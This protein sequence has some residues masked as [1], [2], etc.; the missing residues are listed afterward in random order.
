M[1]AATPPSLLLTPQQARHLLPVKYLP[2]TWIKIYLKCTISEINCVCG[3]LM[4]T[5]YKLA[6]Q[7]F[8]IKINFRGLCKGKTSSGTP[9]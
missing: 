3:L 6:I 9:F 4:F 8:W 5:F 1:D 7:S 2:V